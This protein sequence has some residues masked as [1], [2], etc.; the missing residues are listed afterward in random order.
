MTYALAG[1]HGGRHGLLWEVWGRALG[2]GSRNLDESTLRL[3]WERSGARYGVD[4]C[5]LVGLTDGSGDVGFTAGVTMVLGPRRAGA[6]PA[7]A[8]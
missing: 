4:A 8:R 5:A 2:Q 6:V 1:R 7:A 3:G